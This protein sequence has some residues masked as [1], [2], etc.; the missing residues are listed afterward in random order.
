MMDSHILKLIPNIPKVLSI[1]Q[2]RYIVYKPPHHQP[3]GVDHASQPLRPESRA[4]LANTS[5]ARRT[6][7][8]ASS[9][10]LKRAALSNEMTCQFP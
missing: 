10:A 2:H 7:A 8:I 6:A 1:V 5:R 4:S 3:T 9:Q